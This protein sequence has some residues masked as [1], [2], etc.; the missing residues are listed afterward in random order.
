VNFLAEWRTIYNTQN[1]LLFNSGDAR[2]GGTRFPTRGADPFR[3]FAER[4]ESIRI[5]FP[6]SPTSSAILEKTFPPD[7]LQAFVCSNHNITPEG[8]MADY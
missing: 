5:P 6:F 7:I 8:P 2:V 3:P 4:V 1:C